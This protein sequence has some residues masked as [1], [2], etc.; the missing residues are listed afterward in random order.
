MSEDVKPDAFEAALAA[1]ADE[2]AQPG[3]ESSNSNIGEVE[4]VETVAADAS[5]V[6]CKSGG[7]YTPPPSSTT[8]TILEC[9]S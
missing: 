9:K 7:T 3:I 2:L 8:L 1:N 5:S 4:V 6:F